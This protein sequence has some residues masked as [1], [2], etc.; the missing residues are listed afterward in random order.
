MTPSSHQDP[1]H[2]TFFTVS[3]V[4]DILRVAKSSVYRW[5]SAGALEALEVSRPNLRH[6]FY[7]VRR[8]TIDRLLGSY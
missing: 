8:D 5:I 4:A 3:E 2:P 7:L 1:A 6:R